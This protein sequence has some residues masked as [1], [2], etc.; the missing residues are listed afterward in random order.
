MKLGIRHREKFAAVAAWL[1]PG[2]RRAVTPFFAWADMLLVDHGVF[3][4]FYAN[5]HQVTPQL[6]RSSQ[7]APYQ[8]AYLRRQGVRTVVNLRGGRDQ[9]AY[10]LEARACEREGMALVDCVLRSREPPRPETVRELKEMFDTIAYPALLHCK[11]GSDRAGLA[12]ALYLILRE[13]RPVEEALGQLSLRYG[14]VRQ[15]KTG[16]LDAF[17]ESYLAYVE[18]RK[19][20]PSGGPPLDFLGWV[21][22]VYDWRA[23]K[24][25]FKPT[26]AGSILVDV[27]LRRE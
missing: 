3:R 6:W 24:T 21:E 26:L 18:A 23:L 13:G 25:A 11:S 5:R 1:P 19:A 7:P 10:Y 15:G 12:A 20:D 9:G 4:C 16:V 22:K 27:I 14:H 17:F 8:I 2:L